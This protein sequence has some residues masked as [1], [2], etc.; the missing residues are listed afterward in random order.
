MASWGHTR[1]LN[2]L[3][4]TE[5]TQK[6]VPVANKLYALC[7]VTLGRIKCVFF[8]YH[9]ESFLHY[10]SYRNIRSVKS[11]AHMNKFFWRRNQIVSTKSCIKSI[12]ALQPF[13]H[14]I[15]QFS[16][17]LIITPKFLCLKMLT[18]TLYS[19]FC[20]TSVQY[21][22]VINGSLILDRNQEG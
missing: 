20:K 4:W 16:L 2:F 12:S 8:F 21:M 11:V 9:I 7:Y 22:I 13:I 17:L 1:A 3:E 19:A 18:I 6:I 10:R 14:L 15:G 5:N